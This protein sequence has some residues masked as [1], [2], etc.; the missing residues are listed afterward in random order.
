MSNFDH[1]WCEKYRPKTLEDIYLPKKTKDIISQ[2]GEEIPNLLFTGTPGSGKTSLARIIVQDMLQCDYLYIN[3]SDENGVDTI[4]NKVNGF[5][6]TM[7]FDG[8]IKVVILDEADYLSSSS[9][10]L[11]RNTMESYA[12]TTRFILTGNYRHKIIPALQSRCQ[13]VEIQPSIQDSL[14]RCLYIIKNEQISCSKEQQTLLV[15]LVRTNFPDLR[16]TIQE[17]QKNS[18]NGILNI[19]KTNNYDQIC[20]II[21]KNIQCKKSF[22]TRTYLIQNETMFSNDYEEL[23]RR[24]INYLFNFKINDSIKKQLL[25]V[26][27]EHLYRMA[28]LIDKEIGFFGCLLNM[29]TVIV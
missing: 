1:L 25:I 12:A 20:E 2:Y 10:G 18:N 4:R 3:A 27:C 17:I 6:Q 11:L 26:G 21:I 16:K 22:D 19:E 23:L 29:E 13:S 14:R 8:K 28:T 5:A 15:E 9:Q 24:L 7:S